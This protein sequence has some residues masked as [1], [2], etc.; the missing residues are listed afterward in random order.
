MNQSLTFM[1]EINACTRRN[2]T[3]SNITCLLRI[4]ICRH[5]PHTIGTLTLKGSWQLIRDLV[6]RKKK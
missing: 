4:I 1:S 3:K 2:M 6:K 5:T